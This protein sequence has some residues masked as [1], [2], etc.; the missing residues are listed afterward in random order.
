[1]NQL[2]SQSSARVPGS[3]RPA[4]A[5]GMAFPTIIPGSALGLSG[6]PAPSNRITLAV[7]GTGNQGF[8]DIKSFL[9]DDR[10]SWSLS[11]TPT[12]RAPAIGTARSAAANRPGGSSTSITPRKTLRRRITPATPSPISAK[13]STAKTST[14]SK[15]ALRTT[16]TL[17]GGRGV[18]G[19]ERH[20]LS[21]APL[22]HDRRRSRDELCRQAV[23]SCVPDGQ[24]TAFRPP[25]PPRLRIG[26]QWP[27]RRPAHG[28][29]AAM[30]SGRTDYA[31]TGDHKKPETVPPGFDYNM[32]L[33]PA[34]TPLMRRPAAMSTSA[35]S[36]ITRAAR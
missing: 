27:D 28:P 33:G 4:S 31:K 32:W 8:N 1:M 21:E 9:R 26:S 15:S 7:I 16:G 12:A 19:K 35:G 23:E 6:R 36:T 29:R 3:N 24:S 10:V 25:F 2:S 20:L 18:Q 11:A 17:H 30:P 13:S 34:P 5:A 22:A 14:P